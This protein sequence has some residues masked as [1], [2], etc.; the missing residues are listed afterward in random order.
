MWDMF[1]V[2]TKTNPEEEK[3]GEGGIAYLTAYVIC[4]VLLL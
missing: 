2:T 1:S 3:M 4:H